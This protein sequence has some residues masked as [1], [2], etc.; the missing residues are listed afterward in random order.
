V[1]IAVLHDSK[2]VV[3]SH[4]PLLHVADL[5]PV[6]GNPVSFVVPDAPCATLTSPS[7]VHVEL[8]T[9]QA[10]PTGYV[11][12]H[13]LREQPELQVAGQTP[14]AGPSSQVSI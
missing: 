12:G 10:D 2:T 6:V 7:A 14:L 4:T 1:Q 13:A 5:D 3:E 11:H 9:D 8:P